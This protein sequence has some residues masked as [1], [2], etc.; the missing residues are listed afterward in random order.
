MLKP[1]ISFWTILRMSLLFLGLSSLNR[2]V[3][4][5]F[6]RALFA[7][8]GFM[9]FWT[10]IRIDLVSMAWG[11]IPAYAVLLFHPNP[12]R[13]WKGIV[14]FYFIALSGFFAFANYVDVIYFT[15]TTKRTT[16]DFFNYLGAGDDFASLMPTFAADY[17]YMI[18]LWL[19]FMGLAWFL[20]KF[21]FPAKEEKTPISNHILYSL[22]AFL[23][24][25][26]ASRGGIQ[27]KPLN[28]MD[29][30]RYVPV[31]NAAL[32]LNTPFTMMKTIGKSQLQPKLYFKADEATTYFD[33][34]WKNEGG[35]AD[36]RNIVVIIV[37][38]LSREYMGFFNE[39][40]YTPFLDS[41]MKHSIVFADAYA[42]GKRSIE[43]LPAIFSGLPNLMTEAHNT[44]PYAAN[45]LSSLPK[46]LKPL[47][48]YSAFFHGGAN[49]TMGFNS[50]TELAGFEDYFGMDEYPYTTDYDGNWGIF[51][52]AYLSYIA[53][54]Q[55]EMKEPFLTGIFTLS[56]H[57]PYVIPEGYE[58]DCPPGELKILKTICYSDDALRTYFNKASG[59]KW[60]EN[61]IF[62]I[63]ADHTAQSISKEYASPLGIFSIPIVLFDP[64][65]DSGAVVSTTCQQSDI[66]PTLLSYLDLPS[67]GIFFG[68]D[69]LNANQGLMINYFNEGYQAANTDYFLQF[70]GDKTTAVYPRG[71]TLKP[72]NQIDIPGGDASFEA[73]ENATKALIQ[74]YNN[75][76]ISNQLTPVNG[77]E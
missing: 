36:K 18:I 7:D 6:N 53:D 37:E 62:L 17:Y 32:S 30:A 4:Y 59:M 76:M 24:L 23:M 40:G 75:R 49:G 67:E 5:L 58:I 60:Y 12:G 20:S 61:T 42:N 51:D 54:R 48:Y 43:A 22:L 56:S 50:Y 44:S 46:C 52:H 19:I 55:S 65:L 72:T 8:A 34:L 16:W 68:Q 74:E 70:N 11:L 3:F 64:Q 29:V 77:N 28:I 38:S 35:N 13:I 57:H 73:L 31:Q 21:I 27:L 15:F 47:G 66:T 2:I 71:N 45:D 14:R 10:G 63:T 39:K 33:P 41:L 26:T 69:A 25:A 9:E 1:G